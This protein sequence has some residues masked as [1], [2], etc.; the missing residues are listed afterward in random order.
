MQKFSF[1][2]VKKDNKSR[3]R[4]GII[5]TKHGNIKTPA[6]S[7]VG[8]KGSVKGLDEIDLKNAGS[9]V[10]LANTYHLYLRPGIGV[11]KKFGGLREFMNWDGPMITDSGGYQVSYLWT[12]LRS[13]FTGTTE[14]QARGEEVGQ[15][16]K[17]GD[18]G[19]T[20][21][22]HID[23]SLHEITP[24]KSIQIQNILG[25][26]I[27]MAFDQ[28]G[29]PKRSLGWEERSFVE[30]KRLKSNQALYGIL[31]GGTN[32]KIRKSF[33]DFIIKTGFDGIAFGDATI[34][35]DPKLTAKAMDTVSEFLPDDKP[36]HA[37]GLGGG[38][39]GILTAVER[40]MDTFDN[41]GIT[42]MARTGLLFIYPE[43]GGNKLNKFRIDVNKSKYRDVKKPVSKICKCHTCANYSAAYVH[44]LVV[45]SEPL[46][47]RLTTI[48]NVH[49]VN[50]LMREIRESIVKGH[51]STL[52]KHW[53]GV[54]SIDFQA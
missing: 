16:V 27:I 54:R 43:D 9:Q 26:D 39:E 2:L 52:K 18:K 6:F 29:V 25:A 34:G 3:A 15:S 22:S 14:G 47:V 51:F 28:P 38:P 42:R 44:H 23:G 17:I 48:H 11:I 7:V 31:H 32:R 50:N 10:V 21:R 45:S 20:F 24:E 36:V 19:A 5:R 33:L 1:E 46:G 49:F 12:P 8:T 41:T 37:L 13:G 4:A 40:G 53:L 35:S 30:H